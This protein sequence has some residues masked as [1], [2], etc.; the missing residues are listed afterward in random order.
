[1]S[2]VWPKSFPRLWTTVQLLVL[3]T[4]F[5]QMRK[6]HDRTRVDWNVPLGKVQPLEFLSDEEGQWWGNVFDIGPTNLYTLSHSIPFLGTIWNIHM[7]FI[8]VIRPSHLR[9]S[10]KKNC[11]YF[12]LW[13]IYEFVLYCK[14]SS[15]IWRRYECHWYNI[16]HYEL[17][18]IVHWMFL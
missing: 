17:A 3:L 10:K 13:V 9:L 16:F 1:M 11:K 4:S 12:D 15:F 5:A 6:I 7:T 8:T 18:G 14:L 2:Q